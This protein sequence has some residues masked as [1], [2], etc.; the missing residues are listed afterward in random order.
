MQ[1]MMI[2]R[3]RCTPRQSPTSRA[4]AL[5]LLSIVFAG[6]PLARTGLAHVQDTSTGGQAKTSSMPAKHTSR[7]NSSRA[8]RL[9]ANKPQS[10]RS[11]SSKT[12]QSIV[13]L[14]N[15]QPITGY[16]VEQRRRLMSIG[17]NIQPKVKAIFQS[18][19][20]DPKTT[21]RLKAILDETVKANQGKSQE[22]VIK[23]FERRKK[24][25][26]RS[27][28]Q[29]AIARARKSTMPSRKAA[30]DEL[31][32]E[33]LKLYE[34]KRLNALASDEDVNRVLAGMASRNKISPEQLSKNFAQMG[35]NID[36]MK[37]RIKA[38]VSWNNVI[39]RRYGR[40]IQSVVS[41]LDRMAGDV[42]GSDDVELQVQRILLLLPTKVDQKEIAVRLRD[43]ELMRANFK[44]CKATSSLTAGVTGARFQNLGK[45]APSSIPE[46]TR[47]LLL[48]A[49]DNEMLPPSVGEGGVELWAVCGRKVIPAQQK[50][51]VS[52]KNDRQQKEFEILAKRHLKDLRQDA[53]IEYR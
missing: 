2:F 6:M 8:T 11:R 41:E 7:S 52:A 35:T 3:N 38:S 36:A 27:I 42:T 53:H 24:A 51:R 30:L 50:K 12:A 18:I 17:A 28:Q 49:Q 23:I 9:A 40:Q 10:K 25:F 1:P 47:T 15:D 22:E 5:L 48:S 4:C 16:E 29:Q 26:G 46:P 37:E 44:N 13:A 43:A 31:V 14:V 33:R 45:R 21:A 20:K 19:V 39:R 32:D 34:A